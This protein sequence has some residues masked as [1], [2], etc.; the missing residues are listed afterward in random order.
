MDKP[1]GFLNDAVV[2]HTTG[3]IAYDDMIHLFFSLDKEYRRNA[4]WS[5]N[6]ETALKLRTLK[7]SDGN[8]LWNHADNTIMGKSVYISNYMPREAAGA[9]PI[10]FGDFSYY[11]I[12]DR[13]PFTMRRLNELFV[14]KQQIGFLGYEY[15]DAKLIRPYAIH[16]MQIGA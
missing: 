2:D 10:A 13:K 12:F 8:Y 5:M 1:H 11:W 9:R 16:V 14:A 7:D 15:L 4:V 6:D 3:D